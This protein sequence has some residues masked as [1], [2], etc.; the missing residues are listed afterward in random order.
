M[1]ASKQTDEIGERESDLLYPAHESSP[2][3]P[4]VTASTSCCNVQGA[5][6]IQD[7]DK[8]ALGCNKMNRPPA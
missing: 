3:L 8:S 6:L 4:S 2:L 5:N 7:R 1:S